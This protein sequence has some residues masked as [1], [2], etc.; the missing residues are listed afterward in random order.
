MPESGILG[1]GIRNRA[2]GNRISFS[3]AKGSG[4][5]YL[6]SGIHSVESRIQDCL[7]FPHIE[8]IVNPNAP[9]VSLCKEVFE[10][11]TSTGSGLFSFLDGVFAQFFLTNRLYNSKDT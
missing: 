4:L 11:C 10:R 5:Q 9:K 2:H 6:E 1:F 3:T 7:G 8:R